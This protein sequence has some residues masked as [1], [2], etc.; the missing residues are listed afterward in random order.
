L[1]RI[2]PNLFLSWCL[3]AIFAEAALGG[4]PGFEP[5]RVIAAPEAHQAAAADKEFV[6]AITNSKIAKYDRRTGKR[7]ATSTGEARHL[8]SGFFWKG[9]LY[10]AHSNYPKTPE[11]SEIK[12]LDVETMKLATFK[13]FGDYGG[14]LTWAVRSEGHWW[15]NFARYGDDNA[16]TF[17][18]KFDEKWNEKGRWTYPP[19]IVKRLGR[20]SLSGG[21]RHGGE[22]WVTGHDD[23]V[24]YRVR[25]PKKGRV[26]ELA[27]KLA[28]PF[29]GQGIAD[30]SATGGLVGINRG[31]KQ[32]VFA[33]QRKTP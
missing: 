33:Q 25:L 15:C 6:Y 18:V 31:K 32:I 29:T 23:P 5:A 3:L 2:P 19:E 27:G 20:Y 26:L 16:R 7:L 28:V 13:D 10:A 11:L 22:F 14:S 17:L 24:V 12:V 30:D 4:E 9:K 1:S 21:I 8:N